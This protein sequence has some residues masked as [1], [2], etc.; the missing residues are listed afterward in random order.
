MARQYDIP[1]QHSLSKI[2][3]FIIFGVLKFNSNLST[4]RIMEL[5]YIFI[6]GIE[7]RNMGEWFVRVEGDNEVRQRHIHY[8]LGGG[9]VKGSYSE[10]ANL[11][12]VWLDYLK[13]RHPEFNNG[14]SYFNEYRNDKGGDWYLSK[15]SNVELV[16]QRGIGLDSVG[17]SNWK[18]STELKE[19]IKD[20]NENAAVNY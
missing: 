13:Q 17:N 14:S 1:L 19:R 8:A 11:I 20:K 9:M 10:L 12:D 5:W 4:S 18:M 2:D 3:N 7:V 16:N 15:L 6:R